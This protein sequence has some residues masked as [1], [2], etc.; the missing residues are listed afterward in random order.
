MI[1]ISTIEQEASRRVGT[2]STS[3]LKSDMVS[4]SV[5]VKLIFDFVVKLRKV[6]NYTRKTSDFD[7]GRMRPSRPC[8]RV[9]RPPGLTSQG[10]DLPS[11]FRLTTWSCR[12]VD[13]AESSVPTIWK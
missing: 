4:N 1:S 13:S 6:M 9:R 12:L 10:Y 5:F 11:Y 3:F 2:G 8:I 7:S